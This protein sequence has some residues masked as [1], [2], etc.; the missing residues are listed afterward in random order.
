MSIDAGRDYM[1]CPSFLDAMS[2]SDQ[3]AGIPG[4]P[5]SKAAKGEKL[6]K[7][8]DFAGIA[9]EDSYTNLLDIRRSLREYDDKIP[10]TRAQLA[11]MLYTAHAIQDFRGVNNVATLRPTPSGG[12]RHPFEVYAAVKNVEGLEMGIYRYLPLEDVGKKAVT[13]EYICPID[14]YDETMADMV[15]GQKW[16]AKAPVVLLISCIPYRA[17]WRYRELAH[18]VVLI[19]LGHMGQN[20]MLSAAALGLGSCCMAAYN[21]E[22]CDR[23]VG[24]DG[25][26][27][28]I[29]YA[30][31]VGTAAK[32]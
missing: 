1:K 32:S 11:Y 20:I 25:K 14:N 22:I 15:V 6:I 3:Q 8:P 2:K 16:A 31:S 9:T 19:D 17:E 18:R 12:A 13:I 10:M 5:V 21:Q 26:E 4:P 7:L 30:V 28:Y 24:L 29:V 23:V 27:E